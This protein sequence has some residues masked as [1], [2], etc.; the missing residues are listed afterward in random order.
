MGIVILELGHQRHAP[1]FGLDDRADM[2]DAGDEFVALGPRNVHLDLLP[3]DDIDGRPLPLVN[4]GPHPEERRVGDDKHRIPKLDTLPPGHEDIL[5][6]PVEGR[7]EDERAQR[8][9]I[10]GA[11]GDILG[12]RRDIGAE[13]APDESAKMLLRHLDEP[14]GLG[15]ARPRP[16]P[17]LSGHE[18]RLLAGGIEVRLRH[19]EVA[20]PFLDDPPREHPAVPQLAGAA[21]DLLDEEELGVRPEDLLPIVAQNA[22]L[23]HHL[24]IGQ[25][26]LVCERLEE[27]FDV[28]GDRC[29]PLGGFDL[30]LLVVLAAADIVSGCA[31]RGARQLGEGVP[32]GNSLPDLRKHLRDDAVDGGGVI[33]PAS[34]VV[35]E[36]TG[37]SELI[38]H[39]H[40]GDRPQFDPGRRPRSLR[41]KNF[42]GERTSRGL[43]SRGGLF[44]ARMFPATEVV[45]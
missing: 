4:L 16:I 32:L 41:E 10:A 6:D 37:N 43:R 18:Q 11:V 7:P 1:R 25:R 19:L 8:S 13:P 15:K 33:E 2:V 31:H 5:D 45:G 17:F 21:V 30:D 12:D 14:I 23:E 20:R 40:P 9:G 26:R 24:D 42:G 36:P 3:L 39:R 29:R 35:V 34:R 44:F 27:Q 22:V 38:V 28:V